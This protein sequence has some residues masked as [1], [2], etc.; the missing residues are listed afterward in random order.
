MKKDISKMCMRVDHGHI[1]SSKSWQNRDESSFC[2]LKLWPNISFTGIQLPG[3]ILPQRRRPSNVRGLSSLQICRV[4][5]VEKYHER[6]SKSDPKIWSSKIIIKNQKAAPKICP[7]HPAVGS[8]PGLSCISWIPH[9]KVRIA[10][11]KSDR[12]RRCAS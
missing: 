1:C 5:S 8:Y 12:S 4:G 7:K 10:S 2:H 3:G 11:V 6:S 9:G